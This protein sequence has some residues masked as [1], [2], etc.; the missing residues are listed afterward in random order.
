[1][2]FVPM[3]HGVALEAN[4]DRPRKEFKLKRD[5]TNDE[6]RQALGVGDHSAPLL[7]SENAFYTEIDGPTPEGCEFFGMRTG[8]DTFNVVATEPYA[9][10][11]AKA[12][13]IGN[14]VRDC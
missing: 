4:D 10:L 11:V 1:M 6:I 5:M 2:T 9:W 14:F 8:P 7:V 13:V 12:E 3:A